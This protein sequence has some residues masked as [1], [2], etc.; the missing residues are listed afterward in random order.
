[1]VL[2]SALRPGVEAE[3]LPKAQPERTICCKACGHAVTSPAAAT[4]VGGAHEHTFRNPAGYSFHLLCFAQ[5]PGCRSVGEPTTAA[6]WFPDYAWSFGVCRECG[7]H[8]GWWYESAGDVG[9][10]GLIAT[11]LLR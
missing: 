9:F 7:A 10:A 11:R 2:Q 4:E 3:T 5:A 8:L 6:T 1:M